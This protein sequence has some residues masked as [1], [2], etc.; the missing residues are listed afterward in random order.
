MKKKLLLLIPFA[1]LILSGCSFK[2]VKKFIGEN[3]YIPARE[4]WS[5]IDR[6]DVIDV[7]EKEEKQD[8][9]PDHGSAT[10]PETDPET[11]PQGP[12]FP[13]TAA[14]EFFAAE[15]ITVTLPDYIVA[16]A[17]G[18]FEVIDEYVE[19][20]G[21]LLINVYGSTAEEMATFIGSLGNSGWSVEESEE[22]EG[23]YYAQYGDTLA[24]LTVI[25][26]LEEENSKCIQL[27]FYIGSEVY[28]EFPTELVLNYLKENGAILSEECFPAYESENEE[29]CFE[30]DDSWADFTG[31]CDIYVMNTTSSEVEDYVL[32]LMES[33]WNLEDVQYSYADEEETEIEDVTYILSIVGDEEGACDALMYVCDYLLTNGYVDIMVGATVKPSVDW[34]S[35][36]IAEFVSE[37]GFNDPIPPFSGT[38]VNYQ[39]QVGYSSLRVVIAVESVDAEETVLNQY[40]EDLLGANY[41][42][43]E[44]DSYGDMHYISEHGEID[45]CVYQGSKYGND[46]YVVVD[47]A[48][49]VEENPMSPLDAATTL[50][51]FFGVQYSQIDDTS[52]GLYLATSAASYTVE[53]LASQISMV[54]SFYLEEFELSQDWAED[55]AYGYNAKYL[56][57]INTAVQIFIYEDTLYVDGKG[58][59]VDED[60]EGATPVEAVCAEIYAYAE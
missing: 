58:Y 1:G 24:Y 17:E 21:E 44:P 3:F 10:D 8:T 59:I 25:N 57:S 23:V 11:D 40:V 28:E 38:A 14:V 30:Y 42:E 43:G 26:G 51:G 52:Y 12:V 15:G 2:D 60:T 39:T 48:A 37:L 9:T 27:V 35:E 45:A 33:G 13:G 29:L 41:V 18:S 54:M 7:D 4:A 20:Y 50:A 36:V 53:S 5:G 55:P 22:Y 32:S 56:N 49:F 19:S 34:P 46:G 47:F 6:K 31:A 16:N